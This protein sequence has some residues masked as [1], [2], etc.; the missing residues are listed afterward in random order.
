MSGELRESIQRMWHHSVWADRLL[1]DALC[2]ASNAEAWKE[3]SHVVG[4]E[5]TWLSRLEKRASRAA[6]W[7]ELDR[8]QAASLREAVVTG[9]QK[10]L[11]ELD[12]SGLAQMIEYTNSAGLEFQSLCADILIHVAL[13][14]QYHRGRINLLLRQSDAERAPV[15]YIAFV[16]GSAAATT[17][18]SR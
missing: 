12:E 15:D 11:S 14:G 17:T 4:A 2:K 10:Y 18:S 3:Y 9:Y 13:H 16:R 1:F 7:P 5:E 6:I 8:D